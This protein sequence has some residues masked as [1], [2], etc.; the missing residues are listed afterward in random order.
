M[1]VV[2]DGIVVGDYIADFLI[3]KRVIVEIK[4]VEILLKVHEVQLVNYLNAVHLD[5]GLL[6]N[7]G[8][9][10]IEVKRK[11]REPNRSISLQAS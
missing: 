5:V 7:F 4:A 11:F 9:P 2:Y 6:I 10:K 8:G 1:Q 3:G